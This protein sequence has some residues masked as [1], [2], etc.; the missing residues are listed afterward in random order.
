[1]QLVTAVF[2]AELLSYWFERV[3]IALSDANAT[4]ATYGLTDVAVIFVAA[5]EVVV[6]VSEGKAHVSAS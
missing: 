6:P 5:V 3:I 1:M 2:S 4:G